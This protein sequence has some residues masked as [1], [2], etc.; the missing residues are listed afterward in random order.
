MKYTPREGV[1]MVVAEINGMR[2]KIA[3]NHPT[4]PAT[5]ELPKKLTD[6]EMDKYQVESVD[7]PKKRKEKES[8]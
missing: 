3:K 1:G 8:E 5:F 2:Y 6:V 4:L 7:E